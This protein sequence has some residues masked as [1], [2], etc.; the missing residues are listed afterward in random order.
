LRA[1][2]RGKSRRAARGGRV[3]AP[4]PITNASSEK[5]GRGKKGKGRKKSDTTAWQREEGGLSLA[6][7][8][9]GK[10]GDYPIPGS[11]SEKGE[12]RNKKHYKKKNRGEGRPINPI[13]GPC[14]SREEIPTT[15]VAQEKKGGRFLSGR[16]YKGVAMIF[17][18]KVNP[19]LKG[20]S[21]TR[22][23]KK[24]NDRFQHCEWPE[25]ANSPKKKGRMSGRDALS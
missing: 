2:A 16:R 21:S 25:R 3:C 23:R 8:K 14:L 10:S 5:K 9:R 7:G 4:I 19:S 13:E 24:K 18:K 20:G 22:K 6:S 11:K 1:T 15:I 17:T 12:N